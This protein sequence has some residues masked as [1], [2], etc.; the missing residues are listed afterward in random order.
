MQNIVP[1]LTCLALVFAACTNRASTPFPVGAA[2]CGQPGV[3]STSAPWRRVRASSFTFCVPGN[4]QPSGNAQDS[5]DAKEWSGGGGSVTWDSGQAPRLALNTEM[6]RGVAE[7][8]LVAPP[9]VST[10]LVP[11]GAASEPV[12]S[13]P[14][15]QPAHCERP[16]STLFRIGLATLAVTQVR[17]QDTW[18]TTAWS[19][20]P[21]MYLQAKAR[22]AE[23]AQL[24][25]L[26]VQTIRFT[27]WIPDPAANPL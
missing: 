15:D 4:W 9:S 19:A 25:L 6:A 10:S 13:L 22:S 23:A 24:Q 16:S 12:P 1:P 3:G 7:F 26:M 18:T 20:A 27:V 14:I 2:P 5:T 21:R 8:R 11:S 17:C